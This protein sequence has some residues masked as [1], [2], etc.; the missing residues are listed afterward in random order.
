M[1]GAIPLL[2]VHAFVAQTRQLFSSPAPP[3]SYPVEMYSYWFATPLR[4]DIRTVQYSLWNDCYVLF[5]QC[6]ELFANQIVVTSKTYKRTVFTSVYDENYFIIEGL[7]V[8]LPITMHSVFIF[9]CICF[10]E[11]KGCEGEQSYMLA[12]I[13]FMCMWYVYDVHIKLWLLPCLL[14]NFGDRL[15]ETSCMQ[16]YTGIAFVK[17]LYQVKVRVV[18]IFF[19]IAVLVCLYSWL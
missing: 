15:N 11:N 10:C 13:Q 9:L 1:S 18:T 2:A 4:N 7:M 19:H 14:L 16:C 3:S 6:T 12:H 8:K 17:P 5:I